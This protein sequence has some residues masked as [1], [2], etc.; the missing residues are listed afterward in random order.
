M[1]KQETKETAKEDKPVLEVTDF[2]PV[3]K[4]SKSLPVLKRGEILISETDEN[5]K[6]VNH[7]ISNQKTFDEF[8][9]KNKKFS[10]KKK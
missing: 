10:I 3:Q 2:V 7:F 4:Q 8:Y 9:S 5:G 6:E 1:A